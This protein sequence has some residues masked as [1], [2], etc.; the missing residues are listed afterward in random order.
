MVVFPHSKHV[1]SIFFVLFTSYCLFYSLPIPASCRPA[2]R[3]AGEICEFPEAD[4]WCKDLYLNPALY[5]GVPDLP[6]RGWVRRPDHHRTV[7][8]RGWMGLTETGIQYGWGKT[9]KLKNKRFR[10]HL[11]LS[12]VIDLSPGTQQQIDKALS[13]IGKKF[14]DLDL[15]N[16][17][18][19]PPPPLTLP[20]LPMTS[21]VRMSSVVALCHHLSWI[22]LVSA[23]VRDEF[24][25]LDLEMIATFVASYCTNWSSFNTFFCWR[26]RFIFRRQASVV[27]SFC[28]VSL[29]I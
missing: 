24:H 28:R 12:L 17:Y 18:A 10:S 9:W 20:S 13:L 25:D 23:K 22:V 27:L 4:L 21:W 7:F 2:N 19:P 16:V 6:Y 11:W 8:W 1:A 14:K 3:E 5:T 15:T 29:C 26:C